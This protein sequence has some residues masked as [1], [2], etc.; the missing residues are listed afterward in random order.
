[1]NRALGRW[2][3]SPDSFDRGG[4]TPLSYV[5][6]SGYEGIVKLLLERRDV[7]AYPSDSHG[8]TPLS[9]A[10]ES[11]SVGVVKLLL[12]LTDSVLN[13]AVRPS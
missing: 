1:V 3:V 4:R 13:G 9:F 2:D 10:A 12:E 6:G 7:K 5:A 11:G 8:R